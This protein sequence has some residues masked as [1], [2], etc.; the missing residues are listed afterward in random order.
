M[1]ALPEHIHVPASHMEKAVLVDLCLGEGHLEMLSL[2]PQDAVAFRD[3]C[4]LGV[5]ENDPEPSGQAS[6][7]PRAGTSRFRLPLRQLFLLH[8]P[9]V[10]Y[11]RL[12]LKDLLR[13]KPVELNRAP[14]ENSHPRFHCHLYPETMGGPPRPQRWDGLPSAFQDPL[15]LGPPGSS[16]QVTNLSQLCRLWCCSFQ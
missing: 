8:V 10:M 1:L 3:C 13:K 7:Q 12:A 16:C 6:G 5:S 11:L 14:A 15:C 2:H 4:V 9:S